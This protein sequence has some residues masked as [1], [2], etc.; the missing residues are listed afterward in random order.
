MDYNLIAT[1]DIHIRPDVPE[2]RKDDFLEVQRK[3]LES[4][5]EKANKNTASIVIAG[6]IFHRSRVPQWLEAEVISIFKQA[7]QP[8]Y[9]VIGNHDVD[10][11]GASTYLRTSF[12]VLISSQ[13]VGFLPEDSRML[14]VNCDDDWPKEK[15]D[16]VVAHKFVY[17][18]KPPFPGAEEK[19]VKACNIPVSAPLLISGDNHQSF[20]FVST[21]DSLTVVNPGA[22]TRQ[23]SDMAD[24]KPY[25]YFCEV[26]Q[27]RVSTKPI[28]LPDTDPEAVS[29]EHLERSEEK[30]RRFHVL[31]ERLK[32]P[33]GVAVSFQENLE[34]KMQ[35]A[36]LRKTVKAELQN[37]LT[38]L[39]GGE[40]NE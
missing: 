19:G 13:T 22:V 14:S 37:E 4:I 1:A 9:A 16:I 12:G 18:N 32:S 2:C 5:V 39:T 27:G 25:I 30:E 20:R 8:I 21:R 7:S 24:H 15:F 34:S 29:R 31:T 36:R 17:N 33:G 26:R 10:F 3:T 35:T 11:Y 40:E 38:K 6:D 28:A 23:R